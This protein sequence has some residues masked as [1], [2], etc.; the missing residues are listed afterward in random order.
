MGQAG[1]DLHHHHLMVCLH[2]MT[3]HLKEKNLKMI[4]YQSRQTDQNRL[5]QDSQQMGLFVV[6]ESLPHYLVVVTEQL[7]AKSEVECKHS[8]PGTSRSWEL[9][10]GIRIG[11]CTE[12]N[13]NISMGDTIHN[14]WN[15]T[16]DI[17]YL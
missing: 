1:L 4:P 13:T 2:Q 16:W 11:M 17:V 5:Q 9:A 15:Y 8:L 10:P 3:S 12:C 6:L 7:C 14:G